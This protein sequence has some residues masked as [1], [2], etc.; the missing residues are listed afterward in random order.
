MSGRTMIVRETWPYALH[1]RMNCYAVSKLFL[2]AAY[3]IRS[4]IFD[5]LICRSV[6]YMY[7]VFHFDVP[8]RARRENGHDSPSPRSTVQNMPAVLSSGVGSDRTRPNR[9]DLW[10]LNGSDPIGSDRS[11]EFRCR[12][13]ARPERK[14]TANLLPRGQA[15]FLTFSHLLEGSAA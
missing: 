1:T 5:F 15:C 2:Q 6:M 3:Q 12:T 9:L 13:A 7:S 10:N 8:A 11:F 4:R 14:G